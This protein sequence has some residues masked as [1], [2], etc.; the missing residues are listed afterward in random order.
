[1]SALGEF[2]V[3]EAINGVGVIQDGVVTIY[4]VPED[5]A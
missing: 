4:T 5:V 1:M 2:K 3:L